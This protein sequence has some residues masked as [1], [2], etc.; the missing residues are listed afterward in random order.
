MAEDWMTNPKL[1]DKLAIYHFD[2]KFK[3]R[4]SKIQWSPPNNDI[5]NTFTISLKSFV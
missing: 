2:T 5:K 3:A 1:D 4:I